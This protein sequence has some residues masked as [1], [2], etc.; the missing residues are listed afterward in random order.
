[1]PYYQRNFS[2]LCFKSNKQPN[3]KYNLKLFVPLSGKLKEEFE[4]DPVAVSELLEALYSYQ[5]S[6]SYFVKC[7]QV[8]ATNVSI[9]TDY[10]RVFGLSLK[11]ILVG[12]K[13][14]APS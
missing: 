12:S 14:L 1:M 10:V 7:A 6:V 11:M 13:H 8:T 3:Q 9:F 2:S 5:E 4:F